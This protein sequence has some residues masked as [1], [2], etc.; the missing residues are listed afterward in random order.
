MNGIDRAA[1]LE[2]ESIKA[3]DRD[4]RY[5]DG[6]NQGRQ[7]RPAVSASNRLLIQRS[8][9]AVRLERI[10]VDDGRDSPSF[11]QAW[12]TPTTIKLRD[13][14]DSWGD[15]QNGLNSPWQE[16]SDAGLDPINNE[17]ARFDPAFTAEPVASVAEP[18]ML[19]ETAPASEPAQAA[20]TS[21]A[22]VPS[23]AAAA[24]SPEAAAP[25]AAAPASRHLEP[26]VDAAWLQQ[27]DAALDALAQDYLS[28]LQ[29]IGGLA[30]FAS[31]V[32][33]V[34]Y[35]NQQRE[36]VQTLA[37]LYEQPDAT[38]FLQWSPDILQIALGSKRGAGVGAAPPGKAVA[39]AAQLFAV[40]VVL[41]DPDV[42]TL[43]AQQPPAWPAL[44]PHA[45][46]QT[47]LYGAERFADMQQLSGVMSTV[48]KDYENQLRVARQ[49]HTEAAPGWVDAT[50]L[51]YDKD[52]VGN[53]ILSS[54]PTVITYRRFDIDRFTTAYLTQETPEARLF[55]TYYGASTTTVSS[56]GD[57]GEERTRTLF[58]ARGW[59]FPEFSNGQMQY[60]WESSINP[61]NPPGL[62]DHTAISYNPAVGW[63]TSNDN[64]DQGTDWF[65]V[66]FP[67]VMGALA[68][69]AGGALATSLL[70]T[71]S[72]AAG[73]AA[74]GG[75][76]AGGGASAGGAAAT[77]TAAGGL[78]GTT[79]AM[80]VAA[81]SSFSSSLFSGLYEGNL[82][83]RELLKK[84]LTSALTTGLSR[85]LNS[86]V[87][88]A[89]GYLEIKNVTVNNIASTA[90]TQG[91]MQ[92]ILAGDF[93]K[94]A[95]NG[96][97]GGLATE[98]TK[99]G[100][101]SLKEAFEAKELS[102]T[103][104]LAAKQGIRMVGNAF[105]IAGDPGH[106]SQGAAKGLIGG[107]VSAL[108]DLMKERDTLTTTPPAPTTRPATAPATPV[109]TSAGSLPPRR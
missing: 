30:G 98:F 93:A 79:N 5:P 23:D 39:S 12:P 72:G 36:P 47:R 58:T 29:L 63:V 61:N 109:P 95:L 103:E 8:L 25:A 13:S 54:E 53:D 82:N 100:E 56:I 104:Y 57:D 46:T 35:L 107:L 10:P 43:M 42:Q 27:R 67:V 86:N 97:T 2:A 45:L 105:R 51:V 108:P 28:Q 44:T 62:H 106:S 65:E 60:R 69:M 9:Q 81:A 71:S 40:D 80:I 101:T 18:S 19:A 84:T 50:R 16:D 92:Q 75:G 41:A 64:I 31:P 38:T 70:G 87:K 68:G 66:L 20:V 91:L 21:Q 33:Q 52:E 37:R 24:A 73:G 83:L 17:T 94:G 74:T 4:S 96:L 14:S 102:A 1:T 85:V 48:R 59:Q 76:T 88:D 15:A 22:E 26:A 77:G 34:I 49:D 3:L 6:S 32:F 7:Y 78:A 99:A 11:D 90:L 55:S 89:I